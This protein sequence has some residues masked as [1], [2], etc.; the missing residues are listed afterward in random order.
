MLPAQGHRRGVVALLSGCVQQALAPQNNLAAAKRCSRPMAWKCTSPRDNLAAVLSCCTSAR[1]TEARQ[2][3]RR[4]FPLMP[5]DVDAIITTAARLQLGHKRLRTALQRPRQI[6]S[7]ASDFSSKVMD[8]SAYLA[9][10]DLREPRGFATERAVAYQ[11]ACHLL[12]AQGL[13]SEPRRPAQPNSLICAWSIS[14]M[15]A[16]AVAPPGPTIWISPR[17]PKR[18]AGKR[19]MPYSPPGPIHSRVRQYR[20]HHAVTQASAPAKQGICPSCISPNCFGQRI[21]PKLAG[22]NRR[23]E[24][25]TA[26][27]S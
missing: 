20:L 8:L 5:D 2:I 24:K 10:L 14:P 22:I 13:Q 11:D 19:P 15:L 27:I 7:R 17:L 1:K 18:W 3:A 6:C 21:S 25:R 26:P 23:R 12:H 4:N 16:C 9:R